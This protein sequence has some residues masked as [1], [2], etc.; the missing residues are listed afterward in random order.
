MIE[1]KSFVIFFIFIGAILGATIIDSDKF[2]TY[3]P[4]IIEKHLSENEIENDINYNFFDSDECPNLTPQLIKEIQSYQP[5]V[6][7]IV[8]AAVKG[9]YSGSTWSE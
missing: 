9:K 8:A 6:D 4:K 3:I 2:P 1:T 7:E 5:I